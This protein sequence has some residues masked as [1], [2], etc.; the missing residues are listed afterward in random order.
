MSKCATWYLLQ[1]EL[2]TG[3]GE[4]QYEPGPGRD[5]VLD[6]IYKLPPN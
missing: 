1:F 4:G 3:D 2:Y 5:V 6:L